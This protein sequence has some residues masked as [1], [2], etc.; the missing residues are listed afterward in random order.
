MRRLPV[1]LGVLAVGLGASACNSA[2]SDS[3]TTTT[4]P[5]GTSTTI[6]AHLKASTTT[7]PPAVVTPAGRAATLDMQV[8]LRHGGRRASLHYVSTSVGN[9]VTTTIVGDVN[10]T[11]GTQTV[12]VST[13]RVKVSV[14]IELVGHE[15][16]FRGS[17]AAVEVVIDLTAREAAA[18]AD[19]WVSVVPSDSVYEATAAALTVGSVMSELALSSPITG[20]RDIVAQGQ[21]ALQLSGA[22]TG[23]GI[24]A[25]DR[26]TAELDVT[27]GPASLPL[28][29]NGVEPANTRAS[30]FTASFV[31]GKWGEQ[32]KVAPP[33]FSVPLA[34]IIKATTTTTQ[35]VVV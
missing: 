10:Q 2:S 15:A 12:V 6:A 32:V 5:A 29:F 33:A 35:P 34:T 7:L 22:W 3:S 26:A 9:G 1:V 25:A 28:S 11:A 13:E 14:V 21:P 23:N 31:V 8:A 18:A 4:A 17:A 27:R 19:Q 20:V 30:R 16:Y 24:T